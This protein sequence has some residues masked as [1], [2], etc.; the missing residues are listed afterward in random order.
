MDTMILPD[1]VKVNDTKD[2]VLRAML[3][4]VYKDVCGEGDDEAEMAVDDYLNFGI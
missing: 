3:V 2:E 4:D 1:G